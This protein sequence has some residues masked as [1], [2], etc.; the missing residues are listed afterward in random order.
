MKGIE[1]VC[2]KVS[3]EKNIKESDLESLM[4]FIFSRVILNLS[5]NEDFGI[6]LLK[7]GTFSV[8]LYLLE[9]YMRKLIHIMRNV[10]K[11]NTNKYKIFYENYCREFKKL[12]KLR[13][14]IR[15]I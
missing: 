12:W 7:L 9:V 10:K 4:D 8:D 13:R 5:K 3:K 6:F 2:N 11:K 14:E 15:R 1:Y